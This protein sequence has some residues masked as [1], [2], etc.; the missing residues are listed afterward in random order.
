MS[1]MDLRRHCKDGDSEG[2]CNLTGALTTALPNGLLSA[3]KDT[4]IEIARQTRQCK[5]DPFAGLYGMPLLHSAAR[6]LPLKLLLSVANRIYSSMS[7]GLTNIG[8]I[9]CRL[10]QMGDAL[11]ENGW[12]GGPV[13]QKPGVQISAASF[14]RTCTLCIWGH[15][16][17]EDLPVLNQLLDA[18]LRHID[19]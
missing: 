5:E 16:V 17:Q 1:M 4:L 3:F 2:L 12:F 14:G 6:K 13:K 8:S 11:P 9:D 15:A 18:A 7:L 10:L 19:F